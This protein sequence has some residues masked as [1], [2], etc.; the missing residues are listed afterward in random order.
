MP[1]APTCQTESWS[2]VSRQHS[3]RGWLPSWA[4]I[5]SV[6]GCPPPA[7][8]GGGG[9][10][11]WPPRAAVMAVATWRTQRLEEPMRTSQT[12]V[13]GYSCTRELD[14]CDLTSSSTRTQCDL[15]SK[16]K[17]HSKS[18]QHS[19]HSS[20]NSTNL[21]Q[22]WH[23]EQWHMNRCIHARQQHSR[24]HASS[25]TSSPLPPTPTQTSPRPSSPHL[26]VRRG[27]LPVVRRVRQR[28]PRAMMRRKVLQE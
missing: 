23:H 8:N 13:R 16:A 10:S 24:M 5:P 14:E 6:V 17:Y 26:K 9:E 18:Q 21:H 19:N 22:L 4:K 15:N 28:E 1:P 25:H 2:V 27:R 11:H 20:T 3:R 12:L 7:A